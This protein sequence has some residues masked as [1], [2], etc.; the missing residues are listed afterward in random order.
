[1]ALNN[2]SVSCVIYT[3]PCVC[4]SDQLPLGLFHWNL[5]WGL[6]LWAIWSEVFFNFAI[7]PIFWP[8]GGHL[9]NQAGRRLSTISCPFCNSARF[10]REICMGDVPGDKGVS[11]ERIVLMWSLTLTLWPWNQDS[12]R[13]ASPKRMKIYGWYLVWRCVWGQRC[14]WQK[15]CVDVTFNLDSVTMT[16]NCIIFPFRSIITKRL[17]IFGWYLV[18]GCIRGQRCVTWKNRVD[19]TFDLDS[20]TLKPKF[21]SAPKRMRIFG[22]YL[23]WGGQR[24]VRQKICVNVTFDLVPW[25]PSMFHI[26]L[27]RRWSRTRKSLTPIFPLSK[28]VLGAERTAANRGFILY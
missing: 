14:V 6:Y 20:V 11:R 3:R 12:F 7:R 26:I 28:R 16:P 23:V 5:M 25:P 27:F 2:P 13:S 1:L 19:A 4:A 24:C 10:F 22:W 21:P 9:E 17:K 18:G 15:N 8:L